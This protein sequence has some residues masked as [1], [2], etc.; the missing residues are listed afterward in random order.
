MPIPPAP[1]IFTF[2]KLE[3][4]LQLICLK[5]TSII[6]CLALRLT[7]PFVEG[8]L[9]SLLKPGGSSGA[10]YNSIQTLATNQPR[11]KTEQLRIGIKEGSSFYFGNEVWRIGIWASLWL[12]AMT[13][14]SG[15]VVWEGEVS[16]QGK[17]RSGAWEGG[18]GFRALVQ[19]L[20][21]TNCSLPYLEYCYMPINPSFYVHSWLQ[22]LLNWWCILQ[23]VVS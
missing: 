23:P 10:Q 16:V 15:K 8:E 18:L 12:V 1:H 14:A 9:L 6:F 19:V 20:L 22:L 17:Q 21:G 11:I 5:N 7:P 3:C 4:T 2:L 13:W